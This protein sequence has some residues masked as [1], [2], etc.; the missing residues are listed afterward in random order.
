MKKEMTSEQHEKGPILIIEDDNEIRESLVDILADEGYHVVSAKNG[1]EGLDYLTTAEKRPCLV[2]IDLMMPIMDGK[3]F[4]LEQ[5]KNP[6]IAE[7]P[8]VLFSADGQL[9]KKAESIG[10]KDYLKKP[11]D[12]NELLVIAERYC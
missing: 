4:R 8:T 10:F 11:I 1:K 2:F 3:T 6:E 9:D 7:I 5:S 12:L